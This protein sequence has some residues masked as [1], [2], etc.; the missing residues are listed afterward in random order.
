MK[1]SRFEKMCE[2]SRNSEE[3]VRDFLN[4]KYQLQFHIVPHEEQAAYKSK[5]VHVPDL[6]VVEKPHVAFEIKEDRMSSET[7]N[8]CFEVKC[9]RGLRRYAQKNDIHTV[10][11]LYVN[12]LDYCLDV[13]QIGMGLARIEDELNLLVDKNEAR[14]LQGGDYQDD[15][16][17]LPLAKARQ[18]ESCLT[19]K[20]FNDID[21]FFFSKAAKLRLSK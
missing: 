8:L 15:M 6:L 18:L 20:F 17:V 13:F 3:L 5:G 4:L 1:K 21:L 10:Y 16:Y 12:H 7:K 11:L 14:Y 9:I 2:E 19:N